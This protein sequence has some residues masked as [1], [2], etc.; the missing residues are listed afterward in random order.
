MLRKIFFISAII[1]FF[2][3]NLSFAQSFVGAKGGLSYI[4]LEEL[5]MEHKKSSNFSV[6]VF[7]RYGLLAS[8]QPELNF[9]V[10]GTKITAGDN[11]AQLK[12]NY[13]N[14]P[15]MFGVNLFFLYINAG[16]YYGYLTSAELDDKDVLDDFKRH[17]F[18]F[19]YGGGVRLPLAKQLWFELDGRICHGLTKI[20]ENDSYKDAKNK[21]WGV[22]LGVI[23]RFSE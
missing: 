22:T 10:K 19:E 11:N 7:Y 16:P 13:V 20:N 4:T 6:G 23:Y 21:N 3:S 5:D 8:I 17:D 15:I 9:R 12:L 2:S 18:G 14:T 1:L